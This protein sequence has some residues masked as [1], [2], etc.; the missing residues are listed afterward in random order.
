M[1][2][3]SKIVWTPLLEK[4]IAEFTILGIYVCQVKKDK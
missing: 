3:L 2:I 4:K 1:F